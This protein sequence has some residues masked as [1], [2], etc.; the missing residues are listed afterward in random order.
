MAASVVFASS[1]EAAPP[2]APSPAPSERNEQAM[3]C[4]GV[5]AATSFLNA[6]TGNTEAQASSDRNGR[7]FIA[8]TTLSPDRS[9]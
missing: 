7:G 9:A 6:F 1:Q 3:N 8:A 4:A 2:A 5:M